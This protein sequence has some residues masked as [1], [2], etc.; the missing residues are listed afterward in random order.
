MP[1][2]DH[3]MKRLVLSGLCALLLGVPA[4]AQTDGATAAQIDAEV[5]SARE[6]LMRAIRLP[7]TSQEARRAGVPEEDLR[8]AL[9]AGRERRL[10]ADEMDV[11]L[12]DEVDAV[13]ENGPIDNFGAFVQARLAEGLRGRDLAA[14]IRA[15]HAAHGKGKGQ[16][17]KMGVDGKGKPMKGGKM[18]GGDHDEGDDGPGDDDGEQGRSRSGKAR[19]KSP[20]PELP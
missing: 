11:I 1:L 13:R 19:R 7:E 10:P 16:L 20:P 2:E 5:K 4:L 8:N 18:K 9:R 14:A 17:M 3:L 12:T 6:R 15:E